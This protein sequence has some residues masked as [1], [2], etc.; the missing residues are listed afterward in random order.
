MTEPRKVDIAVSAWRTVPVVGG[1]IAAVEAANQKWISDAVSSGALAMWNNQDFQVLEAM[2]GS[3]GIEAYARL[4]DLALNNRLSKSER[5]DSSLTKLSSTLGRSALIDR[6]IK[7]M[8]RAIP[9]AM[10]GADPQQLQMIAGFDVTP[11]TQKKAE[12]EISQKIQQNADPHGLSDSARNYLT[13]L[14]GVMLVLMNYLDVQNGVRSELC[15]IVPK[16]VPT[17]S[18]S[19]YGK[20]M[21][22][23][24]CEASLPTEQ[25]ARFRM[26]KGE[27][28]RLRTEPGMKSEL[29]ALSLH[30][31]DLIE[32]LDD[33]NR[34]WLYVSVLNEEGV[35][36]WISRKYTHRLR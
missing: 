25:F 16:V 19:S 3:A 32:V 12:Q 17:M 1:V 31:R 21:R 27:G 18:A 10:A 9:A 15:F 33:S 23:A 7:K 29:V 8:V 14:L 20:L 34:D 13:W 35:S 2:A 22:N 4:L 30:D 28:V 26:V 5:L 11:E 36:G 24:M 6:K